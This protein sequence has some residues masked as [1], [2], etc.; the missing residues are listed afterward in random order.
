MF[1][2]TQVQIR[3]RLT[4]RGRRLSLL[5]CH[6]AQAFTP[7]KRQVAPRGQDGIEQSAFALILAHIRL[8]LF[9]VKNCS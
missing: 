8:T 5:P 3:P 2:L 4:Y 1:R 7:G 6:S 9:T